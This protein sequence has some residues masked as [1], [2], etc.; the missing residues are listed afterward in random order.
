MYNYLLKIFCHSKTSQTFPPSFL[1]FL[2]IFVIKSLSVF[3]LEQDITH[4]YGTT[5]SPTTLSV[6]N[7]TTIPAIINMMTAS[8]TKM[9]TT[10]TVVLNNSW[11]QYLMCP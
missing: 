9:T 4:L 3:P 2:F 8:T 11:N 6:P 10:G 1:I 7:I 5:A